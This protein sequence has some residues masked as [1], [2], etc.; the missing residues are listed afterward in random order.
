MTNK[1]IGLLQLA[2]LTF[3]LSIS[4][5]PLFIE[6][7]IKISKSDTIISIIL[8]SLLT[9]IIFKV[10]LSLRKKVKPKN[11]YLKIFISI[12]LSI[13]FI[14][15]LLETTTFIKD[16]Y[17][18]SGNFYSILILLLLMCLVISLREFRELTSLS[19][20]LL[21]IFIPLFI[22]N[23]IGSSFSIDLTYLKVPFTSSITNIINGSLLFFIYEIIPL[24]LLL[25]I[26]YK[27]IDALK[28]Q[29]KY[30]YLAIISGIIV[31]IIDY[32]LL[33]FSSSINVLTSYN[34]PFMLTINSLSSTF[35]LGRLSYLISFYLLFSQLITLSLIICVIKQLMWNK[36]NLKTQE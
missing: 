16:T 27:E 21:F 7:I 6:K 9:L 8:G 2:S 18:S 13:I 33:Y 25:F 31:I 10:I 1:K 17:L 32:L 14:Y 11:K 34:Y 5:F 23:I 28:K 30:L 15:L 19:L 12:L 36:Y 4:S 22:I 35:I 29:D 20:I 26:P 3:F 24:S